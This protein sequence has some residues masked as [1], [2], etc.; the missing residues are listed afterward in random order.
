MKVE[1]SEAGIVQGKTVKVYLDMC[2]Y[3]RPF[4][5]QSDLRVKLETV[6]CEI[7]FDCLQKGE[8]DLVWSFMLE[9]EN[10]M[11]PFT[12]R[13]HEIALLSRLAKHIVVPHR[14]ILARAEEIQKAG[15]AGNDAVHLA[16]GLFSHCDYFVTCD[17]RV[18]HRSKTVDLNMV[19]CS[20]LEFIRRRQQN[21]C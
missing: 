16:C 19:V 11:N 15:I 7:I 14:E 18:V 5:D 3:N 2:V 6:A 1:R 10:E 21:D 8:M 20:P 4:D 13:K 12:G 9:F 17:D